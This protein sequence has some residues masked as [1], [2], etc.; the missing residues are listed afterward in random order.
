M[1]RV[2]VDVGGTFTDIFVHDE[3]SGATMSAK[4]PTTPENQAIGVVESLRAAGVSPADVS[5]MAHGTT[6]GTNA[7]LE[8]TGALTG[9]LTTDGFRD[10]LEIMRTDRESGYDLTWR[11][12]R[13]L[14][15]RR[16]RREVRE[17]VDKD[18][19][20]DLPLDENQATTAIDELLEFGVESIAISLIHS[21]ANPSHERRLR[22][23]ILEIRPELSVSLSSDINA[24]YRE[25]E[26][27][28]TVVIDAYLKPII[29]RYIRRLAAELEN[30]GLRAQLFIMQGSGGMITAERAAEKPIATLGSGPAAGA[31]A[32][33]QVGAQAGL[34]DIVTFDVG[35]TSTDVSLIH[36]G[37]PFVTRAKAIEWG[38]PARVPMIDVESVGAG[39]G[40]IAWIDEGGGLKVGP[41]SAG[42]YPGPI[43]YGRGGILPTLSDALLAKGVLGAEIADGRI[44]LD[45]EAARRGMERLA[46]ELRLSVDRV[47][48]GIVEISQANMANAARS[49]SIWKGLDPRDLTLVAFGGAGGMV[50]G[51]VARALDI[52]RVLIPVYP[53]N[54]CAMGLLMTDMQEDATVA[55]L[56]EA[57]E[58]E[59]ETLNARLAEL[60]EKVERT[61]ESQ[62]VERRDM[63]FDYFADIRH[64]GQIHELSVLFAEFPVTRTTLEETFRSFERMYEDVYTIRLKDHMPEMTSLRVKGIGKVSKYSM[65]EFRGDS[66]L[67]AKGSRDVFAHDSW[68]PVNV[69]SRYSLP[70]GTVLSG[71]AIVEEPG[72]TTWIAGGMSGK[73]DGFGNFMITTNVATDDSR[74]A[75]LVQEI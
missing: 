49:V 5:F 36:G 39:G 75:A 71:P 74:T 1:L 67:E 13:P 16:L 72:S 69:Y 60:H 40:S 73:V 31:I 19:H 20:V 42:A 2:G 8:R 12:P 38:L 51:P 41:Q 30:G 61:L 26:R 15:R 64:Q 56:A 37:Q 6:T 21:Y 47:V 63:T 50:A 65:D 57:R 66:K 23:L 24:E 25:F 35:G 43:C 48:D 45:R 68:Q 53:G 29:V 46:D 4:V 10:V 62:G 3:D 32:A 54:T 11:K 34:G 7:L 44:R 28:N 33:A 52:P 14:V 27:T 55:Y 22:E 17:R 18:G 59:I 70:A 9:L 58:I